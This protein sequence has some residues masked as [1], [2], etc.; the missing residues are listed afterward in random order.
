MYKNI[1]FYFPYFR[2]SFAFTRSL[3]LSTYVSFKDRKKEYIA[4]NADDVR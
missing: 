2:Y 3:P 1:V 4:L